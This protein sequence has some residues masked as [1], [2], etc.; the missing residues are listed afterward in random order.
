MVLKY[1]EVVI[2]WSNYVKLPT[3]TNKAQQAIS[4]G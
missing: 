1:Y 2:S 4:N 3:S